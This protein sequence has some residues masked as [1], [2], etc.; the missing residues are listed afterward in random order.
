[1][2]HNLAWSLQRESIRLREQIYKGLSQKTGF[3]EV[4]GTLMIM[5]TLMAQ[6]DPQKF[7]QH[8]YP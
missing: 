8:L 6:D 7:P 3:E 4:F 5:K 1:M 2:F